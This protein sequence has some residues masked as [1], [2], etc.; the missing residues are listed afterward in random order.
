MV[1]DIQTQEYIPLNHLHGYLAKLH[2]HADVQKTIQSFSQSTKKSFWHTKSLYWPV[3][4][5]I[6]CVVVIWIWV[7]VQKATAPSQDIHSS[8]SLESQKQLLAKT[9][10]QWWQFIV[11]ESLAFAHTKWDAIN[12]SQNIQNVWAI[13]NQDVSILSQPAQTL[14]DKWNTILLWQENESIDTVWQTNAR[15]D[16]QNTATSNFVQQEITDTMNTATSWFPKKSSP[17]YT[18]KFSRLQKDVERV[19]DLDES[20]IEVEDISYWWVTTT[21]FTTLRQDILTE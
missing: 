16:I 5:C 10:V 13:A 15:Q 11:G 19:V 14:F 9:F 2:K 20:Y 1:S 12:K 17:V 3:A 21:T 18:Y 6:V 4:L 7:F 8:A